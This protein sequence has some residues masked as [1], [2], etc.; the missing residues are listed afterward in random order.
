MAIEVLI[1][2]T[3]IEDYGDK[4][5]KFLQAELGPFTV[6]EH[7][8]SFYR[9]KLNAAVSIGKLFGSFEDHVFI[10]LSKSNIIYFLIE[11]FIEYISI[12]NQTSY[13]WTNL[14][15]VCEWTSNIMDFWIQY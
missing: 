15:H 14:Q 12:F 4:I 5:M 13:H 6:L 9:F 10:Y 2:Y 7:F 8:Q 1:E 11:N 3:I